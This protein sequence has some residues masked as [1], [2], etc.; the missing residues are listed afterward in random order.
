MR[1]V[2]MWLVAAGC[3]S[4]GYLLGSMPGSLLLQR[5][6]AQDADKAG[7]KAGSTVPKQ[8]A[9]L[10]DDTREK[11]QKAVTAVTAAVEALKQ[12]GKWTPATRNLNLTAVFNGGFNAKADLASDGG[13][14]PETFAALYADL[15]T[16]DIDLDLAR[17]E[18][19]LLTYKGRVIRMY[20]SARLRAVYNMRSDVTGE[21]KPAVKP[22]IPL[23]TG[24]KKP[25]A[26]AKS[27]EAT[28]TEEEE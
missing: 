22:E 17:N 18:Q 24:T 11:I 1:N 9:Q 23:S 8:L 16:D 28:K 21:P 19:G 3:L 5:A 26:D 20:N 25:G 2:S 15:A 13:V 7:D 6:V 27:D 10:G 4:V 12:E 14:D